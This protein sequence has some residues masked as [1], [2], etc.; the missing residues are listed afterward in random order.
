[1][2]YDATLLDDSD[3]FELLHGNPRT[4]YP[5]KETVL[6]VRDRSF[7]GVVYRTNLDRWFATQSVFSIR[8]E[9]VESRKEEEVSV[10]CQQ[11]FD[12]RSDPKGDAVFRYW[13]LKRG[14]ILFARWAGWLNSMDK[15]MVDRVL[16]Y[17]PPRDPSTVK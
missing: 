16:S 9:G 6:F 3:R 12:S 13:R 14:L 1:V 8:A 10:T 17:H 4:L 11:H 7:N 5:P 2:P 15:E